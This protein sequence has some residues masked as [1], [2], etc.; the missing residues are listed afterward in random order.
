MAENGRMSALF[1][2]VETGASPSPPEEA[3][4]DLVRL[5]GR[6]G[7]WCEASINGISVLASPNDDPDALARNYGAARER[8]ASF[9]SANVIPRGVAG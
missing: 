7:I 3:V 4:R 5:A 2:R 9:V 1:L 6:I 8:R